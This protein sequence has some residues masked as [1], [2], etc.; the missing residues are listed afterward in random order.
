MNPDHIISTFRQRKLHVDFLELSLVQNKPGDDAISYRGKG[1]IQQTEDDIL[2]FK[3]YANETRNTDFA[4]DF[5]R[6]NETKS[7]EFIPREHITHAER[8]RER[9]IDM[10]CRTCLAGM[11]I[12]RRA[13]QS[14]V[15]GKLSSV[16]AGELVPDPKSIAMHFFEGADL[17]VSIREV[18]FM[19][20]G[21]R[22]PRRERR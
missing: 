7:G 9:W 15:H 5:N 1:Y 11:A 21:M 4:A 8:H 3:L 10:E 6:V 19:A 16:N 17:P 13:Q 18:K 14:I 2:T 22:I 12:A 20:A